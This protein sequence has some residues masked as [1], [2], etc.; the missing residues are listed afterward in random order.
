[1]D[2]LPTFHCFDDALELI[3]ERMK[4]DWTV[5]DTLILVHGIAVGENGEPYAHAWVEERGLCWDSGIIEGQRMYYAITK[6]E[7]YAVKQ[8]VQTTKY[9]VT[10]AAKQNLDTRSYGPWEP[11]YQALCNRG[12]RIV[13]RY[14]AHITPNKEDKS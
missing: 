11:I 6:A 12:A 14:T 3:A 9:T 4:E 7:F 1:M 13:G 8:I 5:I 2:I 10:E